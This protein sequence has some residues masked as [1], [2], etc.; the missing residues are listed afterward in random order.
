VQ[1]AAINLSPGVNN[2]TFDPRLGTFI[3]N[4][5]GSVDI[6]SLGLRY[7]LAPVA[8]VTGRRG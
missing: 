1:D 7:H 6:V 5:S 4:S 8:P 2:P 3:G